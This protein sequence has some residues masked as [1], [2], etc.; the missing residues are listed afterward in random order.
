MKVDMRDDDNNGSRGAG[1]QD[2]A[3][4]VVKLFMVSHYV[5]HKWRL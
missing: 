1:G 3:D 4:C 5:E 2:K